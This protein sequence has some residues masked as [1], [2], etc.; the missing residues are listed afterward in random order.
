[1]DKGVARQVLDRQD[2]INKAMDFLDERDTYRRL[3]DDPPK[4][5]I[6]Q[7]NMLRTIKAVEG[8][9]DVTYKRFYPTGTGPSKILLATQD[10]QKGHPFRSLISSR[11]TVKY[12]MA[13]AGQHHN[14]T[15]RM[16]P[17]TIRNT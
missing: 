5:K 7:I 14:T 1:M 10:P 17:T 15:G 4:N 9:W 6:K 8:L 12:G 2:N 13:K 11:G 16:F 3:T